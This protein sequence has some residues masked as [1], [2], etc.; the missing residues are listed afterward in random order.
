MSLEALFSQALGIESPWIITGVAF[1]SVKKRLDIKVDFS[2]GSTFS[3]ADASTEDTKEYKAYDTVE[4]TW[5]HLNFFEHECY[6]NVR[7]PRIRPDSGGIKLIAPP[8]V[9]NGAGGLIC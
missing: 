4:K 8:W 7:T 5:R 9:P 3:S 6:L 1:D 2:K